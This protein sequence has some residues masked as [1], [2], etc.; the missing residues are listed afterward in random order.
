MR[1]FIY[2]S[3]LLATV[4]AA[5]DLIVLSY[6]KSISF[7]GHERLD[8]SLLKELY[9]AA[10]GFSISRGSSWPGMYIIDP[11]HLPEAVVNV[12]VD[13]VS[14][15][16]TDFGHR[17]PLRTNE[18]EETTWESLEQRVK[19]RYPFG[20]NK[21]IRMNL[22]NGLESVKNIEELSNLKAR[23]L[24]GIKF[25]NKATEEDQQFL[26]D[27]AVLN[28]VVDSVEDG[29]IKADRSP[30][31][32]WFVISSLHPV[33]DLHGSNSTATVEAKQILV[34]TLIRLND[35]FRKAYNGN[36]L[37]T[38]VTSDASHTRFSRSLLEETED[39]DKE[40]FD[41]SKLNL[42]KNYNADYP[43]IFNII[44]W[45]GVAMF[46]SLLA[47][48]VVIANMDPGRDSIIYR[49]TSNRMKKDN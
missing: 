10:M 18:D 17:Y 22:D 30:D 39:S 49:M 24:Q 45:F 16:G 8:Q 6:P 38:I 13:G 27:I 36:A 3:T 48:C 33:S 2:F 9:S 34:E 1:L 14:D 15:I 32:F 5:G 4:L 37:I 11:F 40:K 19:E 12:V 46:F 42:A 29:L 7:K 23:D 43:V 28:G 25:L 35:A 47:I 31:V 44:L 41:P 21:L 20:N 26:K